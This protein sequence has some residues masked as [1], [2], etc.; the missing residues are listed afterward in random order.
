MPILIE[1]VAFLLL[2]F[3]ISSYIL[4]TTPL[5]NIL[6][7]ILSHFWAVFSFS[8]CIL[9]S[10]RLF[11]WNPVYVFSFFAS[12]L[13]VISRKYM[14]VALSYLTLWPHGLYTVHGILQA[15][16]LEWVAIPFSRGSS[17]PREPTQVSHIAGRPF[18]IWATREAHI[19]EIIAKSKITKVYA[20]IFS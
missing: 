5:T 16:I 10:T 4:H 13:S 12:I 20:Y 19:Q 11:W 6:M 2:T 9:W 1:L 8:W 17:Q 14:L 7:K 18:T 3:K 15:R